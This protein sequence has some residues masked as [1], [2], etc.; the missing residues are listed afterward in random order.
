MRL[1][2]L[3]TSPSAQWLL[4]LGLGVFG[5]ILNESRIPLLGPD[6]PGFFFGGAPVLLAFAM[7]GFRKGFAAAL[8]VVTSIA[9]RNPASAT[10]AVPIFLA[11]AIGTYAIY[12]RTGSLAFSAALYW[13][14]AGWLVDAFCYVYFLGLSR[15]YTV[16]VIEKQFLRGIL[17]GLFAEGVL[18][19]LGS[20][21]LR[22]SLGFPIEARP[23]GEYVFRR[24]IFVVLLPS[25]I[26]ALVHRRAGYDSLLEARL[27][28]LR[29]RATVLAERLESGALERKDALVGLDGAFRGSVVASLDALVLKS[30]VTSKDASMQATLLDRAGVVIAS[31]EPGVVPGSRAFARFADSSV[32]AIDKD[33]G[34]ALPLADS[35][36]SRLG[37]KKRHAARASVIRNGWIVIVALSAE[38]LQREMATQ[39]SQTLM[40]VFPTIAFLYFFVARLTRSIAGP[41]VALGDRAKELGQQT[42]V[43]MPI[44]KASRSELA[45]SPVVEVRDLMAHFA[46]TEHLVDQRSQLADEDLRT[47]EERLRLVNLAT[48]ELVWDL[49]IASGTVIH[50]GIKKLF[51]YEAEEAIGVHAWWAERVHPEDSGR[52]EGV[53]RE[54]LNGRGEHWASEHR[55]RRK[56]GSYAWVVD[57]AFILRDA[58]GKAVRAIGSTADISAR[59]EAENALFETEAQLR[60]LVESVKVTLWRADAQTFRFTYVS[61]EAETVLG[62]PTQRWLEEPDFWREHIHEGDREAAMAFWVAQTARGQHHTFEYRMVGQDGRVVWLRDIVRFVSHHDR[63]SELVGALVDITAIKLRVE[64]D[65]EI[66]KVVEAA[67]TEW[68]QT[69]DTIEGPIFLVNERDDIVQANRA[70]RRLLG[71]NEPPVPLR[72][73][74]GAEP[75]ATVASL[76]ERMRKE[77]QT[78]R[79]DATDPTTAK[80]WGAT[81]SGDDLVEVEPR[82][83]G[84]QRFAVVALHDATEERRV[85]AALLDSERSQAMLLSN[86]SGMAYRCRNDESW[87]LIYVSGGC[88]ELT[89]H[90]AEALQLGSPQLGD[91][92]HRDDRVWLFENRQAHLAARQSCSNEYRI[93]TAGG[94]EKWVWDQ[95]QC[96]FDAAGRLLR[97]EGFITDIT[98]RKLAE[99]NLQSVHT[100]AAMGELVAGVAH[101]VRNPLFGISANIDAFE[102]QFGGRGE[103][104]ETIATLRGEVSRLIALMNDLLDYGRPSSQVAAVGSIAPGV[105]QAVNACAGLARQSK[106]QIRNR[107]RGDLPQIGMDRRRLVQVFQNLIENAIQHTPEGGKVDIDADAEHGSN[108]EDMISCTVS[109]TGSGFSEADLPQIFEPFFSRR[110]GGT[111][112]GLAIV[113]RI[114]QEHGGSIHARNRASQGAQIEVRLK[115][116]PS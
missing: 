34:Y 110:R 62:Y 47:S 82:P 57:R 14:G 52:V 93:V 69:F 97:L 38:E 30:L 76:I 40:L 46:S 18:L 71:P 112:L 95:A 17:N 39:A 55:F 20:S 53:R 26:V 45:E 27:S 44:G 48:N 106:I 103:Y 59:K 10:W 51:G 33:V 66:R 64:S 88:V 28:D 98:A 24:I 72:T 8:I 2:S 65:A 89:G 42:R 102:A 60:Q 23:L 99:A 9:A 101:E 61:P 100:M 105:A 29:S 67:A 91:L 6:S 84:S 114:V 56:D 54:A 75:W 87:S 85:H 81:V 11:E 109:D 15:D 94:R 73:L 37:L 83:M 22:R 113:Q 41:I 111:G 4:A 3:V 86:L 107:V 19:L 5:L 32:G 116:I 77:K 35:P 63:P 104:E 108:G 58:S 13:L 43:S 80:T 70:T 92:V 25:V 21:G 1:V 31:G 36:L 49:D 115:A 79:G 78:T 90:S 68:E 7:L 12:R 96:V 50:E 16:L 74:A